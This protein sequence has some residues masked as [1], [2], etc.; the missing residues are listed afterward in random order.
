MIAL[1]LLV[2]LFC[3]S[4][5][6]GNG[7]EN[8]FLHCGPQNLNLT[9]SD[10]T[11]LV[12]WED[13]PS[14][15]AV[16]DRLIY[17]LVVLMADKQVHSD[18]VIVMP[19]QIGSTH[20]WNWTSHLA[21]ECVSHSVRLSSQYKNYKSPW[22][23][24]QTL[25]GKENLK[26]PEVYPRDKVFKVGS[27][28]TFCCVLP[29]GQ[30]FKRMYLNGYSDT[31]A[32]TTKISNR[33]YAWTVHLNQPSTRSC[34]DVIC[35]ALDQ[36]AGKTDGGACA[37]IDYPPG[38]KDL[39]CETR[40]LES[41]KCHWTVGRK[42][43][44]LPLKKIHYELLGS[45]CAN[46][47]QGICSQN[48]KVNVGEKNWTLTAENKVGKVE[49]TDTADLTKRVHMCAPEGLT[50]PSVNARNI[51]LEWV[52]PVQQYKNLNIRCQVNVSYGRTNTMSEPFGVGLSFAVLTDLIP[53]WMYNVTVRCAT[54]QDFWKWSDWSTRFSFH[55][56]GDVPDALDVWMHRKDN[57]ILI[58]W[59][60][61][62]DNQSH[63]HIL[64][65]TVTWAKTTE[66]KHKNRTQ[67][68]SNEHHLELSLDTTEELIV[69]VTASNLN[70]S[71]SPSA[72]TIPRFTPD[73]T[74][75]NTSRIVGS[76]GSFR[77]SWSA[78][79]S[80]SCGYI[81]DWCPISD[82][83]SMEWLKVPPYETSASIFSKNLKDG[84]RNN[85]SIYACTQGAPLLLEKREGYVREKRIQ[86][87]FKSPDWNQQSSNVEVSWAPISLTEQ[88]A[89]INGYILYWSGNNDKVF[90][91]ST[92]NPKATSLTTKN[93]EIGSYNFTL[94]ALTAVG[95]CGAIYYSTTFNSPTDNLIKAILISL[96]TVFSLLS[97]IMFFCYR[98]WACIKQKV[99]PPIPNPLLTDKWWSSLSE[100]GCRPLGV[101]QCHYSEA[102][103]MDVPQL[104]SQSGAPVNGYVSHE[105][106]PF[107]FAQTPKGYYN[108][109]L[110]KCTPPPLIL[111]PAGIPSQSGLP[112]TSFRG[113]FP[114]PSYNLMMQNGDQQS[115]PG[116][117]PQERTC[118][119]RD[120]S[121]YQPQSHS[122]TFTLN[123]AE[124]DPD[125]PMSCVSTY[126]LLP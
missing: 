49:L 43:D 33:T 116:P 126:I 13:D 119:E 62:L 45:P 115:N 79:P 1:L 91:V 5:Q 9:S 101:H 18:E 60:K 24:E 37:T 25:P 97:L 69:T 38:D 118:L 108:Q 27:K 35:E 99:Y 84:V 103:I 44:L 107:V 111:P 92:D 94:K 19:D 4:T 39:Q 122:E 76:N 14:C 121:G 31:N 67:V 58:F 77:L 52:L 8:G 11:I 20:F 100:Q 29:A 3:K 89:F 17:E 56:K 104:Y 93:L 80:A 105:N 66:T 86:D 95:E 65:Y 53:N 64:H 48:V 7:Q 71:S 10:Q 36:H 82:H 50:A 51:S 28:A 63:G 47:S 124:D 46:G 23:R 96:V 109:P 83:W 110:K 2:S 98:H 85:L 72:I 16:H 125:S 114:N 32:S 117:E 42:A 21:L 54:A 57:Q 112:S 12:T 30:T 73:T 55:T 26:K 81:V 75:V 123:T 40:D 113:M 41:V 102:D 15:S 6:D 90:N 106:M 61:P 34:N 68:A 22:E 74:R 87:V 88:T 78:S 120:S 70:G 59:K